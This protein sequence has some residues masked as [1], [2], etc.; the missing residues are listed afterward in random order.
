MPDRN[1]LLTK[2]DHESLLSYIFKLADGAGSTKEEM[3]EALETISDLADPDTN[4][5]EDDDG[6]W[7]VSDEGDDDA[8]PD[9]DADDE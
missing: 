6:V 7:S 2:V 8:D 9:A 3:R 1:G 5:E 4:V